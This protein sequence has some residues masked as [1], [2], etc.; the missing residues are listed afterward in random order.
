MSIIGPGCVLNVESFFQELEYLKENG[1]DTSL[2]KV[3][4]RCHIVTDRHIEYDKTKLAAKLGTTSRGIAPAYADKAN[5]AGTLA[6]DVLPQEYLWDEKLPKSFLAEGAQGY[7]LDIDAKH[8]PY[9]TSS[10]T[11]P[12]GACSLGFAPQYIRDIYGLCKAYDTRSGEDPYFPELKDVCQTLRDIAE[13]GGERG[14]TTGRLRKVNWLNI[15]ELIEA[16]NISGTT[17]LVAN[18]FDILKKFEAPGN[19]KLIHNKVEIPFSTVIE[20]QDYIKNIVIKECPLVRKIMFCY[21]PE[22]LSGYEVIINKG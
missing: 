16:I 13:A 4:P 7:H 8:Y 10:I 3:S 12:Y 19:L 2:V 9:V 18:K 17:I 15:D 22:D 5:R 14:V 1:F 20:M 11:I 6:R 21:N